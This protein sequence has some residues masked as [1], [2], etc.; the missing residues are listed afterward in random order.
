M[1]VETLTRVCVKATV[2]GGGGEGGGCGGWSPPDVEGM[3]TS[4]S[5]GWWWLDW[6]GSTSVARVTVDV[7]ATFHRGLMGSCWGV[8]GMM[9]SSCSP[10][11]ISAVLR[12]ACTLHSRII[13]MQ[14]WHSRVS[15]IY[16]KKIMYNCLHI[17]IVFVKRIFL[18][19][20]YVMLCL[21]MVVI[22]SI[23]DKYFHCRVS[24]LLWNS[25]CKEIKFFH[26]FGF[27]LS[28]WRCS[29]VFFLY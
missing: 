27:C 13:G 8:G 16:K 6:Q 9:S 24:I 26:I 10:I 15:Y 23:I 17:S 25:S 12:P 28:L 2:E 14:G 5:P 18:Y 21:L 22:S 1:S 20:C 29:L 4:S 19:S 3:A 7:G 11:K